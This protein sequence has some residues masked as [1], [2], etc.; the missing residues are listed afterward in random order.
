MTGQTRS[1][2]VRALLVAAIA[3]VLAAPLAGEAA[4]G[5]ELELGAREAFAVGTDVEV[6]DVRELDPAPLDTRLREAEE[7]GERWARSFLEIGL[8]LAGL[9]PQGRRQE[10]SVVVPGEWE[11]GMPLRWAR[12]TVFDGDSLDDA[13]AGERH[14]LWVGSDASGR[15]VVRRALW[16]RL[17]SRP[18]G[19]FWSARP[20]P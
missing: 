16:A 20:C 4:G 14:V 11:P 13:V 6:R 18:S 5:T 10:V 1:V 8:R 3:A 9:P 2:A 15:L 17:C 7:R 12:V 19:R